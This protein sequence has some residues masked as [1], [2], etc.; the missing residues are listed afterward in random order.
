MDT[1]Y[2]PDFGARVAFALERMP[3][4]PD[5]QVRQAVARAICLIRQDATSETIDQLMPDGTKQT[6]AN[7]IKDDALRAAQGGD[8]ISG[9][10]KAIKPFIKFKQDADIAK[11][12]QIDPQRKEEL[13]REFGKLGADTVEVFIR[14][15]DQSLL[16]AL[17]GLGVEDCDGFTMYG[18][19]LLTALGIPCSLVTVAAEREN[20]RTFSH[21]YV[22][23]YPYGRKGQRIP[24][25]FSH[26]PYPGWECPSARLK[27]WPVDETP[28]ENA[29]IALAPVAVA[30][31]ILLGL[32]W[33]N[34]RAA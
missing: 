18:A 21:I 19:C 25:D 24:L 28:I 14:P 20:P 10:W 15:A 17:K 1:A 32:R 29:V 16:I 23:A 9:V 33:L 5:G 8:P 34:S 30:G 13:E 4:D 26:G 31:A 3:D 22:A 2:H 27:E 11:D 6:I 7:P 12:L